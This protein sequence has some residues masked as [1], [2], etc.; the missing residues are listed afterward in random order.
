VSYRIRIQ[1]AGAITHVT[2]RGEV[3][4]TEADWSLFLATLAAASAATGWRC[5]A[6]CLIHT[7]YHLLLKTPMPNLSD[8]MELLNGTYAKR[9]N[10]AHGRGGHV[11]ESRFRSALVRTERHLYAAVRYI[12]LN[13]VGAHAAATPEEWRWSSYPATAGLVSP[14]PWLDVDAVLGLFGGEPDAARATYRRF[15]AAGMAT[16]TADGRVPLSYILDGS[17]ASIAEANGDHGYSQAQIAAHLG[18]S[19]SAVSRLLRRPA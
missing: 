16:A 13:P 17:P 1:F 8:G 14:P 6:Y 5:L 7:H 19:Q 11:F 3:F 15:V 10:A 4:V 18:I 12:V 2:C 9:F